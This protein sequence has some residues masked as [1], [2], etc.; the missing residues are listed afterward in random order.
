VVTRYLAN[1]RLFSR[2]IR[3]FL[4]TAVLVGLA[5][6]GVRGVLF[7]LYLLRLGYGP[8]LIGL[9]NGVGA[10]AFALMC[11]PAGAMGSRWSSRRM[12][13]AG[14]ALLA[15]GFFSM[16]LAEVLAGS[17]RI[18][19]LMGTSVL[20]NLGLALYLVNGLPFMMDATE[21]AERSHVFSV[22]MALA[23]LA[24]FA[25]SLLGGALP[26]LLA[27]LL[28]VSP[29]ASTVFGVTLW[30]ASLL[31]VP[32]VLV[33]L[34]TTPAAD[35]WIPAPLPR[36]LPAETRHAPYALLIAIAVIMAFRFGG[37]GTMATFFNVYLDDGLGVSAALIGTL[38]AVSQ[39]LSVPAALAAPLIVA[40]W[41]NPRTIF[42]GTLGMAFCVLPL[43]L[44]PHWAAAGL[45]FASSAALFSVTVG[46]IR[47]FSQELVESRWRATMAAA[48]MTGAGLAFSGVSL[49]GGYAI[50]AYGYR[51]VF[52]VAVGLTASGG[53]V[54]WACFRVP[55]GEFAQQPLSETG[56][57]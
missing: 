48:F 10:L 39:L 3:L 54:F 34:H 49:A 16:P 47:M 38:A 56:D 28:G 30:L 29:E 27:I 43:A 13:I 20:T 21:P 23:P 11:P 14:A 44:V 42:W 18:G 5:W 25:G 52:L 51:A 40:R 53:L 24:A 17:W 55:R 33:L 12:L 41:G 35:R 1:L 50:A 37:R 26:G 22:H 2:D 36:L 15:A 8:E 7:N 32:G 9:I 19:W 31:L 45:G 4:A 46:P 57:P 6:D